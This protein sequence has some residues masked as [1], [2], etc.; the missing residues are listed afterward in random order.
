MNPI[1]Y[2]QADGIVTLVMDWPDEPVNKID[3]LFLPALAETVTRLEADREAIRGVILSSA[4]KTFCAGA[5][6][7]AMLAIGPADAAAV[8]ANGE[9]MKALLRRIEKLGRPVVAAI[10]GSALGGGWEIGLACHHRVCLNDP[11][12]QLGLP[13]VTLGLMPGAG[14]VVRTVRRLGLEAGLSLLAEGKL[15]KPA[16]AADLELVELASDAADLM[17]RA[18]AWIATNPAPVQPWDQKGYKLPGGGVASPQIAQMIMAAPAMLIAKTQGVFPAPK[19][20]L[21]AAVEGLAVDFDT[22]C[23]IESRYFTQLATG[24]VAKNMIATLFFALNEVKAG[25]SRPAA[26]ASPPLARVGILGAG[27]MGSGIAWANASR[28]ID[29]VLKD[30]SLEAA[31]TGK[32]LSRQRADQH[33]ERGRMTP[34]QRDQLLARITTTAD[35][36]D[37]AGCELIIEA[38][39]ESRE[40][41][42]QVMREAEPGLTAGALFAS[43]SSTLPISDLAQASTQPAHFVG[44]H[45]CSPT[46]KM[47][48]VEIIAGRETRP[49]TV[50]RAYDYVLQLGLTPIVVN[51]SRG[52][53]TRRVISKL[54]GEAVGM[55]EE[56]IPPAL[57]ERASLMAGFPVGPLALQDKLGLG[58]GLG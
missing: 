44:L 26:P 7:K 42:A 40:L 58:L 28:G 32:A 43:T 23:R 5:D 47:Q 24:P 55:V 31:E 53:Y 49:A 56:G 38:V 11:R 29:C 45:F 8:F 37:L 13:E 6:L 10:A 30:V 12:I 16:E 9:A 17:A 27:M 51:D 19:A 41:K 33:V 25:A 3:A 4:K 18:R 57:I 50:A 34:A 46:D 52:F 15:M 36:T 35:A 22:A 14:G 2:T 1:A 48:L 20:I 39:P 21:C 54:I